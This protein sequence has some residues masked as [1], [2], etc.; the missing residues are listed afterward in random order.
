LGNSK[1]KLLR[2]WRDKIV[3]SPIWKVAGFGVA[4]ISLSQILPFFLKTLHLL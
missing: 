2:S 3:H 1:T 4:F